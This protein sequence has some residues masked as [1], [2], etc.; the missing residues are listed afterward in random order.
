[1]RENAPVLANFNRLHRGVLFLSFFKERRR[2]LISHSVSRVYVNT[3]PL[4][5]PLPGCDSL[6]LSLPEPP[7]GTPY[8]PHAYPHTHPACTQRVHTHIP[9]PPPR[10]T[11]AHART[12]THA[13]AR[14]RTRT[15]THTPSPY[16]PGPHTP[17]TTHHTPHTTH[18]PRSPIHTHTH[19]HTHCI[20]LGLAVAVSPS[21][22]SAHTPHA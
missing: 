22:G 15:R 10:H 11:H 17:H 1:M 9:D 6:P 19:T 21:S 14:T 12:R 18:S 8:T 2:K 20:V 3:H 4:R 7:T 13:H 5:R 16:A